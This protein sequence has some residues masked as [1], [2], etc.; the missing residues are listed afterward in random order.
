MDIPILDGFYDSKC[1]LTAQ[2]ACGEKL[3]FAKEYI[4]EHNI[5]TAL[6]VF[7]RA[8]DQNPDFLPERVKIGEMQAGED[9]HGLYAYGNVVLTVPFVGNPNASGTM[10]ELKFLGIKNV[11]CAGSAGLID[12]NFDEEK[13]LIIDRAIRDEGGSY[14]YA[15]AETYTYTD[16]KI[17]NAIKKTFDDMGIPYEVGT[18]WTFDTFYKES[19]ERIKLRKLQGAVAVEMECA[20]FCVVAR[21]LGLHFGQFLFFSDKVSGETWAMKGTKEHRLGIKNK[22]TLLCLEIAKNIR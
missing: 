11:L 1:F 15:P 2:K 20:T 9:L 4:K 19:E 6:L 8:L 13:M 17:T 21:H 12:E 7:N 22:I 5:K 18:T 3:A 16:E 14:H 10:E